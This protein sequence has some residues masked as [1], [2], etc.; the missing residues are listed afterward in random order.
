[1]CRNCELGNYEEECEELNAEYEYDGSDDRITSPTEV[2]IGS[3]EFY[4]VVGRN[5]DN[6]DINCCPCDI[7]K[8]KKK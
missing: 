1:M 8:N 7:C 4:A 2:E 3:E 6:G 5:L